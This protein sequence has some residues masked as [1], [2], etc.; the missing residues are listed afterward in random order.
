LPALLSARLTLHYLLYVGSPLRRTFSC[1]VMAIIVIKAP[2]L[3]FD[4]VTQRYD[5]FWADFDGLEI[6]D[7]EGRGLTH[8]ALYE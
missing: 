1:N 6:K 5:D 2:N 3:E 4:Q 7:I 8:Q